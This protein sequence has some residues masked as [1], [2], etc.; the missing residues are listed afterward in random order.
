[1]PKSIIQSF[2]IQLGACVFKF[3]RLSKDPFQPLMNKLSLFTADF[4]QLL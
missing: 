2:N 4:C 1:M 3:I